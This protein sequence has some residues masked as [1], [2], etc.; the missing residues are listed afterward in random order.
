MLY[1]KIFWDD[2]MSNYEM[3]RKGYVMAIVKY[4]EWEFDVE[5]IF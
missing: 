3:C 2:I 5:G 4:G 1:T